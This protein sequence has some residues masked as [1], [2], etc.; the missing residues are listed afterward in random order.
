MTITTDEKLIGQDKTRTLKEW[1]PQKF[2]DS[3]TTHKTIITKFVLKVVPQ[4][5]QGCIEK[6]L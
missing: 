3:V 5:L 6:F 1:K 2:E 4:I